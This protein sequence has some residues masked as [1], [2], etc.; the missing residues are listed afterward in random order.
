[1]SRFLPVIALFLLLAGAGLGVSVSTV[2]DLEAHTL[3][4]AQD[5]LPIPEFGLLVARLHGALDLLT[6]SLGSGFG[7]LGVGLWRHHAARREQHELVS[8]LSGLIQAAEEGRK[9]E[10]LRLESLLI[11]QVEQT[12]ELAAELAVIRETTSR[13]EELVKNAPPPLHAPPVNALMPLVS[14]AAHADDHHPRAP[15]NRRLAI[16]GPEIPGD[17][18]D[19]EFEP[20]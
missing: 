14:F 1:M 13:S 5:G 18:Q 11:T 19:E 6:L 17:Q 2:T 10:T 7:L 3:R 16:A 8:H 9:S 4:L 12:R 15:S 20:F